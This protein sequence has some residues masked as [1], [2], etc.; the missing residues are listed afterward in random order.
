MITSFAQYTTFL[1]RIDVAVWPVPMNLLEMSAPV[2]MFDFSVPGLG[3]TDCLFQGMKKDHYLFMWFYGALGV[4][5]FLSLPRLAAAFCQYAL[6][7]PWRI[8][9][10]PRQVANDGAGEQARARGLDIIRNNEEEAENDE[11]SN[12]DWADNHG[13]EE[14][15]VRY[16]SDTPLNGNQLSDTAWEK[17]RQQTLGLFAGWLNMVAGNIKKIS[18]C[19]LPHLK[20]KETHYDVWCEVYTFWSIDIFTCSK[21]AKTTISLSLPWLRRR[22]TC[23][24]VDSKKSTTDEN[25]GAQ[26][27]GCCC[28]WTSCSDLNTAASSGSHPGREGVV[29]NDA[30]ASQASLES[31]AKEECSSS[32]VDVDL[33]IWNRRTETHTAWMLTFMYVIYPA[34]SIVH[35]SAIVCQDLNDEGWRMKSDPEVKCSHEFGATCNCF[36]Q[37]GVAYRTAIT[38]IVIYTIGFVLAILC[39]LLWFVFGIAIRISTLANNKLEFELVNEVCSKATEVKDRASGKKERDSNATHFKKQRV[40]DIQSLTQLLELRKLLQAKQPNARMAEV[41]HQN[42]NPDNHNHVERREFETYLKEVQILMRQLQCEIKLKTWHQY[43][44][45]GPEGLMRELNIGQD[46]A[47]KL[48]L[49]IQNAHKYVGSFMEMYKVNFYLFEESPAPMLSAQS[50]CIT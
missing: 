46:E 11:T 22:K 43:K 36:Y 42:N 23:D 26:E 38:G 27:L 21:T 8:E 14:D 49:K 16:G 39:A 18:C 25:D 48:T 35:I 19:P 32:Q 34:I 10:A 9:F 45:A 15:S 7:W 41:L 30:E 20:Y 50:Q 47:Q 44:N 6:C 4:M 2:A 40:S 28:Q 37:D 17:T 13:S 29:A 31:S 24:K 5:L 3:V 1:A 12:A 33:K